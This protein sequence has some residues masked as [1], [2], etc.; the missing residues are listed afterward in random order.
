MM[1]LPP[2]RYLA[3]KSA[4]DAAKML[5]DHAP[6]DAM[7]VSGGTDLYPNMKRRQFEPRV[8]VGLRGIW[9]AREIRGRASEGI[10]IPG[11]ATLT[12]LENDEL[13]KA[14]YPA[15]AGAVSLVSSPILR[16]MGTIGGNLC[17]DTRCT[18]YNQNYDWRASIQFCMKKDGEICWVAPSSPRCW[19]VSSS[20]TAP[21]FIALE[22][23][24]TLVG[25]EGERRV[26]IESLYRHDGIDFVT[27]ER[28]EILTEIHV[29]KTNGLR[30]T[31][32]KLRRRDSI[33][34]PILGVAVAVATAK[35]G[36]VERAKIVLTAVE[37][38]PVV[39]EKAAALLVGKKLTD[40]LIEEAAALA[41]RPAKP[42]DN[43]D[44]TNAYRKKMAKVEVARALK[45]LA[46]PNGS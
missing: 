14:H 33:D 21:V 5:R 2:F 9:G 37:S 45:E 27:K 41:Y 16:N 6:E 26:P 43:T 19:A 23:E 22:A 29:P 36:T 10:T 12:E 38:A 40:E 32:R 7:P 3:P 13:L 20:D 24:C 28:E 31:Y 17:V 18:Y 15:L 8:L 46:S 39:A 34:F 25:P 30:A 44:L 11:L 42:L 1:R 4:R 35:D